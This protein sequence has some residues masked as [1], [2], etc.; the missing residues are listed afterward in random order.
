MSALSRLA[1]TSKNIRRIP[2]GSCRPHCFKQNATAGDTDLYTVNWGLGTYSSMV[3]C[4][5]STEWVI[6]MQWLISTQWLVSHQYTVTH[7]YAMT[8]KYTV[9][10]QYAMIHQYTIWILSHPKSLRLCGTYW[11]LHSPWLTPSILLTP[12]LAI[13]GLWLATWVLDSRQFWGT[14]RNNT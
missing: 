10:H 12:W 5:I 13:S 7:Q 11:L 8:F 3:Y 4:V 2:V 14:R 6:S 1:V 9:T